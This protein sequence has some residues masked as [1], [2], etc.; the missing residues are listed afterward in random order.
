MVGGGPSDGTAIELELW[1]LPPEGF[2]R[3]VAGVP[4]PL[5]IGTVVLADGRAVKGLVCEAAAVA[6]A[7]EITAFGGW[8]A[9][10]ASLGLAGAA[11]G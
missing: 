10:R 9:Y 6:G 4:A 5:V 11:I 7:R 1:D 2:G 8:Q 3:L